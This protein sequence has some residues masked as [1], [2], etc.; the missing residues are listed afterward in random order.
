MTKIL[1]ILLSINLQYKH[2]EKIF[3]IK[4]TCRSASMAK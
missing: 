3:F 1:V 2:F 4:D